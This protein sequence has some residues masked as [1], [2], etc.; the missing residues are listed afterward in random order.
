M[1]TTRCQENK[2]LMPVNGFRRSKLGAS[3]LALITPPVWAKLAAALFQ[4]VTT[5]ACTLRRQHGFLLI[6]LDFTN[7]V[8]F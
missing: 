4:L 3:F 2:F 1:P 6:G 8:P 7:G 5:F